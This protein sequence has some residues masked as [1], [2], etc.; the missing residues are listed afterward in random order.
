MLTSILAN[1]LTSGPLL[2]LTLITEDECNGEESKVGQT[3]GIRQ[4]KSGG[5]GKEKW[6]IG[7][8]KELSAGGKDLQKKVL[9]DSSRQKKSILKKVDINFFKI[10]AYIR[11]FLLGIYSRI[12]QL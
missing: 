6:K 1:I 12:V 3:I 4:E 11:F 10:S 2:L 8:R 5:F 7:V 9:N